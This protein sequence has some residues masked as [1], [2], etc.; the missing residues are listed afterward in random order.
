MCN[1][2]M[3]MLGAELCKIKT[4]GYVSKEKKAEL[5]ERFDRVIEEYKRL[6]KLKNF[7]NGIENYVGK[8][9]S[10]RDELE[11]YKVI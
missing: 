4:H 2:E 6:F 1:A 10:R 3:I 9:K 7:E 5:L 8:L 11:A